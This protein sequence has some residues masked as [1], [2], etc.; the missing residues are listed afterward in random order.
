[1]SE[2][3]SKIIVV[4]IYRIHLMSTKYFTYIILG[5]LTTVVSVSRSFH[6]V[7]AEVGWGFVDSDLQCFEFVVNLRL[8][9]LTSSLS[10]ISSCLHFFWIRIAPTFLPKAKPEEI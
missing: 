1:M 10:Y 6:V 2:D 7:L 5:T 9:D 3:L 4:S 8:E